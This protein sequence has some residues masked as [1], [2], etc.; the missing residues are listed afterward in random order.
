M[1]YQ[2]CSDLSEKRYRNQ[3]HG[4]LAV[5]AETTPH[6]SQQTPVSEGRKPAQNVVTG[7]P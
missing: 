1:E 7:K 5:S 2:I 6:R 3:R 4:A